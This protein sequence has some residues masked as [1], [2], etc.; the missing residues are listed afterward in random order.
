MRKKTV[1]GIVGAVHVIGVGALVCLQGCRPT[2]TTGADAALSPPPPVMPPPTFSAPVVTK[3]GPSTAAVSSAVLPF[4]STYV[5][6]KGDSIS[7]IAKKFG[8]RTRDIVALNQLKNPNKIRVGQKILLPGPADT[9]KPPTVRSAV[10]APKAGPNQIVVK[11]GDTLSQLAKR[12][13]TTTR[14]LRDVNKLTTDMIRVNQVLSLPSGSSATSVAKAQTPGPSDAQ[15]PAVELKPAQP[16]KTPLVAA[17][18][19]A[20]TDLPPMPVIEEA[21]PIVEETLATEP[22][23]EVDPGADFI[24]HTVGK[25]ED[26]FDVAL[27]YTVLPDEVRRLNNLDGNELQEGQ[28]LKIKVSGIR[29]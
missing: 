21:E 25:D 3:A 12:H 23:G 27:R 7:V 9:S 6:T 14:A 13:G 16:V 28:R 17:P 5:V 4:T 29:E 1:L 24:V 10:V 20:A 19:P 8:V 15:P 2:T 11:K 22:A 18:P 26:V